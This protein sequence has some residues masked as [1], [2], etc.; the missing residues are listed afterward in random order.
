MPLLKG[1]S[2]S[3]VSTNIRE[4]RRS[5]KSEKQATAIALSHSR[6]GGRKYGPQVN[7]NPKV[8]TKL[9]TNKKPRVR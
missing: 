6:K 3:I 5:G 8:K 2:Q 9:P 4:L 1:K 7:A